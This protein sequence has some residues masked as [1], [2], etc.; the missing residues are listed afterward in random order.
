MRAHS[1]SPPKP[2]QTLHPILDRTIREDTPRALALG[3]F[4][5]HHPRCLAHPLR[6][7]FSDRTIRGA[8]TGKASPH[9]P[10]RGKAR[11]R[12]NAPASSLAS[13]WSALPRAPLSR[14]AFKRSVLDLGQDEA[15][16]LWHTC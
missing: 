4:T 6:Q 7:L 2:P 11:T 16:H 1:P 10:I 3:H 13:M 12:E 8:A 9:A 14:M 15:A 5:R